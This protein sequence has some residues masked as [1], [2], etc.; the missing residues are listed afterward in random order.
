MRITAGKNIIV[1][2]AGE[3]VTISKR[4]EIIPDTPL[5]IN[6]TLVS[7]ANIPVGS[8][9][10]GLNALTDEWEDSGSEVYSTI[11]DPVQTGSTAVQDAPVVT[12]GTIVMSAVNGEGDRLDFPIWGTTDF[13][14]DLTFVD[15]S[16]ADNL[17]ETWDIA[18]GEGVEVTITCGIVYYGG[19]YYQVLRNLLFNTTG[20][21]VAVSDA[22]LRE[23]SV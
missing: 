11:N 13:Y 21:L 4:D 16:S 2:Q 6:D 17:A 1:K 12:D 22:T 3:N 23:F 14:K 20:R 19:G 7:I 5:P 15:S 8:S 9:T 18:D 10:R